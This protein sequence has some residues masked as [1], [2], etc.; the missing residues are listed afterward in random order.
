MESFSLLLG[1]DNRVSLTEGNSMN[2][3]KKLTL[4]SLLLIL[5]VSQV[6]ADEPPENGPH[7][8]Y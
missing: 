5:V 7:V 8:E 6:G 2:T 1:A 4:A 3:Y